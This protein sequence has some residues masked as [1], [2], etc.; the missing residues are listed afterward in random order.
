MSEKSHGYY[1]VASYF[2]SQVVGD[3]IPLRIIPY[4]VFGT[5]VWAMLGLEWT[6]QKLVTHW[7]ALILLSMTAS[8][9]TFLV[10][11]L[12]GVIFSC[13]L[14]VS[15]VFAIMQVRGSARAVSAPTAARTASSPSFWRVF[16]SLRCLAGF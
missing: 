6:I 11:A 13:S 12:V 5:I 3:F 16:T 4:L 14:I 15:A 7:G 2:V 8:S 9:L 10:S 1:R